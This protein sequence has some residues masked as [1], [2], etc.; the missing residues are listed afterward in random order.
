MTLIV[1]NVAE[2]LALQA[3]LAGTHTLKLYSNNVT[4]A[5]TD[6][7]AT[8]TEVV[9]GGYGSYSLAFGTW[10]FVSGAPS[11]ALYGV[12][13]DFAFTGVTNS[14]GV[15]YGYYIVDSNGVLK[16]MERFPEAAVPFTPINGSLIRITP[17]IEAS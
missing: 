5:E 9:G 2:V 13:L 15:I 4:P 1:P 7:A 14:P 12:A 16:F 3:F 10:S 11:F 8:Y 6:T 17:R